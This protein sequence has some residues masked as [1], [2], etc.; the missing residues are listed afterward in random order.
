MMVL[1][2]VIEMVHRL[3]G[4]LVVLMLG[5]VE[6]VVVEGRRCWVEELVQS[7]GVVFGILDI[8]RH[9]STRSGRLWDYHDGW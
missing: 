1:L 2:K 8:D 9:S 3:K 5:V 4:H 7:E 6:V